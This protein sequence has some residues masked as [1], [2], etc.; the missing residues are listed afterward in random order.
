MIATYPL[1]N[2]PLA[3]ADKSAALQRLCSKAIKAAGIGAK[4]DKPQLTTSG[5]PESEDENYHL[6]R[7]IY[8][9]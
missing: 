3:T 8:M 1:S 9:L 2:T 4:S 5:P 7:L 6:G